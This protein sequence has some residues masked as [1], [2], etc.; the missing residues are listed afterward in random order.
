MRSTTEAIYLPVMLLTVSLLGGLRVAERL[1]FVP[2]PLF[3]LV[4]GMLLLGVLI[5]GRV[6]DPD[7]LMNVSRTALENLN[8]VVVVLATFFASAQ[9]FNLVVPESGLPF[10]LAQVFLFVLLVNTLVGFPDRRS[11]L[12]SLAVVTGSAFILK[13][14]VLAAL[15]EP[16]EGALKRMLLVLVEGVTLG[17]LSQRPLHPATGY[18]AFATL[19]LY[20]VSIAMLPSPRGRGELAHQ[21]DIVPSIR[22]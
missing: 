10:L 20:L 11:V 8:G 14:I 18:V 7:R 9:I 5:R 13:F 21:T 2:P 22:T 17:T 16:G 4:L 12:R 19:V 3:T 15:S 6:L 1:Q